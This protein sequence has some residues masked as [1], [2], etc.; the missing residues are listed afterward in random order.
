MFIRVCVCAELVYALLG[1][2]AD[3]PS[4]YLLVGGQLLL[5]LLR[6]LAHGRQTLGGRLA[7]RHRR[8]LL[9]P[10]IHALPKPGSTTTTRKRRGMEKRAYGQ[11]NS[12]KCSGKQREL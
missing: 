12:I 10:V 5:Q 4:R 7:C 1:G 9:C 2:R 6:A 8:R 11:R 3:R